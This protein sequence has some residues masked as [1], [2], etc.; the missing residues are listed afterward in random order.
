MKVK[1]E[2]G[3]QYNASVHVEVPIGIEWKQLESNRHKVTIYLAE[4]CRR[5][6]RD[7]LDLIKPE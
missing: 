2:L 5:I 4:E 3:E 6:E 1:I 7:L